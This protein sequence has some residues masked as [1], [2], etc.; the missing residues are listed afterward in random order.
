MIYEV[1]VALPLIVFLALCIAAGRYNRKNHDSAPIGVV[2]RVLEPPD[3]LTPA[4]AA[5]LLEGVVVTT[6]EAL[7]LG[8]LLNL[9]QRGYITVE[10]RRSTWEDTKQQFVL[11]RSERGNTDL[12]SYERLLLDALFE[13][14]PLVDFAKQAARLRKAHKPLVQAVEVELTMRGYLDADGPQRRKNSRVYNWS[15]GLLGLAA[16]G[17]SWWLAGAV[18]WWGA[19]LLVLLLVFCY[20]FADIFT[21]V[22]GASQKGSDARAAWQSFYAY[23]KDLK[24]DAVPQGRFAPFLPY[25]VAFDLTKRFTQAYSSSTEAPPTWYVSGPAQLPASGKTVSL[26]QL[27]APRPAA[28]ELGDVLKEMAKVLNVPSSL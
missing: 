13:D 14:A 8:T 5:R 17:L 20:A 11:R 1:I 23:L 7:T 4:L 27:P 26:Q 6:D 15:V 22:R 2:G 19:L 28:E 16:L 9:A 12:A 18:V 3:E 24:P 21:Y 25:A 10:R